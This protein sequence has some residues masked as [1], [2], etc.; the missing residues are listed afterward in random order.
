MKT[1]ESNAK[2]RNNSIAIPHKMQSKL[3]AR[4]NS[5]VQGAV[6]LE[7]S[8]IN[9]EKAYRRMTEHQFLKGY[10]DSDSIYDI[11]L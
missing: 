10:A 3:F 5:H 11:E 2:I 9:D 8:E 7:D 6:L 1:I 4:A